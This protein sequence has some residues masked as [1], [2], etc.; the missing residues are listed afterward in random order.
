MKVGV[1]GHVEW[2]EFLRVEAVPAA[3]EI[4]QA[5][6]SWEEPGGAGAVAAVELARMAG[7]STL[8]TVLG[9]DG[10]GRRARDELIRLGVRVASVFRRERQRR[11][12]VY[13]DAD[14][15][16]TITLIGEK[17]R[18]RRDERLPWREL[19]TFDALYFTAGDPAALRA[20]RAA[21]VLVA[22]AR[23]LPTLVLAGVQLDA[24]VA[25]KSDA[26]ERYAGEL[27]PPPRLVVRTEGRAGGSY[28]PQG[29][30]WSAASLPGPLADSYGA[31]DS[32]AAAL[33][34]ALAE[35][36]GPD[37]AIAFAAARGARA[38]TRR[39]AHGVGAAE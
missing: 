16:R 25:S 34:F 7:S 36:R 30:T 14:G 8:F 21:R 5:V 27:D 24:L 22:T 17:L 3:G 35:G 10:Y 32:F 23:E 12:F 2:L 26:S 11:G 31:G 18:P 1:V 9:D 15:E 13:V 38:L 29:G 33:T 20:A 39:G 6:E 4:V 19:E 28:D 37:D